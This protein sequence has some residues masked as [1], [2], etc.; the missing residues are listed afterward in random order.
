M[1][2]GGLVVFAG[3]GWTRVLEYVQVSR[4]YRRG[5][6]RHGSVGGGAGV[7]VGVGHGVGGQ[8]WVLEGLGDVG[9]DVDE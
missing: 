5:V 3:R 1:L 4:L 7:L 9:G 6:G 2:P 8:G